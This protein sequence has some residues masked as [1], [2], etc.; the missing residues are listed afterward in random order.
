[1]KHSLMLKLQEVKNRAALGKF[2]ENTMLARKANLL[3]VE[4]VKL[5]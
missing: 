2:T 3:W 4:F 5:A 1:M